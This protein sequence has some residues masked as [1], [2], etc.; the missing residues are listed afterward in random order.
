MR[1]MKPI[2]EWKK[3][4]PR[5]D[6]FFETPNGILYLGDCMEIMQ[7][8]PKK[9]F[10]LILTDIPY[11]LKI[12]K[13]GS[14]RNLDKGDVNILTFDLEGFLKLLTA[15][16]SGSVY[17]WCGPSQLSSIR[18]LLVDAGFTTRVGVW[19]KTNPSPMNGE[20]L[21]L[22]GIELCVYGRLPKATF[23][24]FCKNTVWRFPSGSSKRHP[25]EK[26]LQLFEYLIKVSSNEGDLVL[27]PCLGS[28]TTAHACERLNRRWIGIEINRKYCEIAQKR[29]EPFARQ[30]R[31]NEFC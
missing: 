23:N 28:G 27:D 4:F 18:D 10:P 7:G 6:I 25:T 16:S 12:K 9:S 26:P 19:E 24:E 3:D 21:W 17:I 20:I 5:D 11:E 31:L 1:R 15:L 30:S 29:L 2:Q 13:E 8:F 22:S 14:L